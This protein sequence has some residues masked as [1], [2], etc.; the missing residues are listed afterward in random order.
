MLLDEKSVA[1]A[2]YDPQP[3]RQ[4]LHQVQDRNK[5]DL[6]QQQ[7]IAPLHSALR[8]RDDA[9]GIGVGEHDDNARAGESERASPI[10]S[11]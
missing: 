6:Q 2:S 5:D 11:R 3:N 4:F 1:V 8:R 10:E 9:S 7:A